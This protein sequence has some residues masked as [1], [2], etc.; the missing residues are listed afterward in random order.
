MNFR[1]VGRS[2]FVVLLL[3]VIAPSPVNAQLQ[4]LNWRLHGGIVS[5]FS[6]F[7]EYFDYGPT[8]SLDAGY[9]IGDRLDL[10]VDLG[11]D[12]VNKHQFYSVPNTPMFRYQVGVEGDLLGDTGNT[13]LRAHA[14]VGANTMRSQRFWVESRPFLEGERIVRTSPIGSGG[15]RLGLQTDSGLIWWLSGSVNW[16]PVDDEDASLLRE[17]TLNELGELGSATTFRITLGFNLN[18]GR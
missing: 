6:D 2:W 8:V 16:S 3:A 7:G 5:P 4:D 11:F 10:L 1:L 14:G 9:P 13:Y 18:R 12:Y 17:G 15:V